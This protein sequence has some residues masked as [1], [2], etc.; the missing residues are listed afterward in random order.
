MRALARRGPVTR[1]VDVVLGL[2]AG[3]VGVVQGAIAG[4]SWWRAAR[5]VDLQGFTAW[6]GSRARCGLAEAGADVDPYN[7]L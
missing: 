7:F 3:A 5:D 1:E 2:G 6:T 4:A